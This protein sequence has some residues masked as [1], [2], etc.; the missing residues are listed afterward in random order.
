MEDKYNLMN[1]IEKNN[2]E[3]V[4]KLLKIKDINVNL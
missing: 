4:I 1:A 2:L 3:L